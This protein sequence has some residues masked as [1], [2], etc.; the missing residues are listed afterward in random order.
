VE[1]LTEFTCSVYVDGELPADELHQAEVHLS[2]CPDCRK[3]V[4]E[5]REET[6]NWIASIQEIDIVPPALA[7]APMKARKTATRADLA[8]LGGILLGVTS[9]IRLAMSSPEKFEWPSSPV[10]LDWLDF[11]ELYGRLSWLGGAVL[12]YAQQGINGLLTLMNSLSVVIIF[13]LGLAGVGLLI[14]RSVGK[15]IIA[16]SMAGLTGVLFMVAVTPSSS[17]A[18]ELR[19]TKPDEHNKATLVPAGEVI[20]DTLFAVG[21]S[22]V[23]DGTVTGDL[24]A[25]ARQVTIHGTVNGSVITAGQSVDV[26]G[27]VGGSIIAAGNTIQVSSK[28]THNFA[29]FGQ[30]VS[31]GKD[32]SIGGDFAGFGNSVQLNGSVAHNFY[33]FGLADIAGSVGRNAEFRGQT[34]TLLPSAR[35]GGDLTSYV[36]KEDMV[37][38]NAGAVVSGK[39]RVELTNR[40]ESKPSLFSRIFGEALHVAAAFVT[41]LLL[42]FLFPG[43]RNIAFSGVPSTLISGGIGFLLLVAMPIAGLIFLITVVGI[44]ISLILFTTWLFGLYLAKIIVANFVGRTL[45]DRNGDRLSTAALGLIVGLVL[46]F[47]AINLP[48][49][50]GLIHFILI[51]VGFGGLITAIYRSFQSRTTAAVV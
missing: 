48:Y 4:A 16:T 6:R 28:V 5:L 26:Q 45:M 49:I 7:A 41:G 19:G 42:L 22:V 17:Y 1:C 23:I 34:L 39:Q 8:K 32:G 10:N 35:I 27:T 51:L 33:G 43:V 29:G 12:F 2:S 30:S 11:S 18:I 13:A 3:L 37:H 25:F 15:G 9:L 47:F 38:V 24:I 14:R 44:P 20:D 31:V 50:G 21:D 46:V 40:N 36:Q